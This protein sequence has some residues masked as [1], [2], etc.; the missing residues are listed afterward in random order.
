[1]WSRILYVKNGFCLETTLVCALKRPLFQFAA[2]ILDRVRST[3]FSVHTRALDLSKKIRGLDHGAAS[4]QAS[5][6]GAAS[7]SGTV[8]TREGLAVDGFSPP[9]YRRHTVYM[10]DFWGRG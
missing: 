6:T 1:M 5:D 2:A 3:H 7:G 10:L 9:T 4:A 8:K